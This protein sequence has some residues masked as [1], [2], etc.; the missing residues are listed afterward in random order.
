[1]DFGE[2]IKQHGLKNTK[3]RSAIL[4]I[5][6]QS[7]QPIS[8]EQIFLGLKGMNISANLS[9]VYRALDVLAHKNLTTKLTISGGDK[10]LYEFN[11]NIHRHYL[12]C[13]GCNKMLPIDSCPLVDYEKALAKET[14]Y[15][16]TGHK[17]DMYGYCPQCQGNI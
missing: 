17:L 2:L 9:T 6:E 3:S 13:L 15:L 16:I 8:A 1:M 7:S 14:N 5:L 12:V 11:R 4:N 10:T